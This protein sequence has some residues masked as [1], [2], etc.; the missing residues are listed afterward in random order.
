MGHTK[1]LDHHQN[2]KEQNMHSNRGQSPIIVSNVLANRSYVVATSQ[3]HV[4]HL[5]EITVCNVFK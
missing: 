3:T 1:A 5:S 4:Q 2:C